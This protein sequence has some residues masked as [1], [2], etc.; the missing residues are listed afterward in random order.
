MV[1]R[2]AERA[3]SLEDP[4]VYEEDSVKGTKNTSMSL[5]LEFGKS[6]RG[7]GER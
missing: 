4:L 5:K 7:L 1:K 6:P 3:S 2:E